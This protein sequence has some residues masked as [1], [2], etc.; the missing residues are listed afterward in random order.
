MHECLIEVFSLEGRHASIFSRFSIEYQVDG[1][2]GATEDTGAV[3]E[4]LA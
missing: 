1:E 4:S 3:E 2:E